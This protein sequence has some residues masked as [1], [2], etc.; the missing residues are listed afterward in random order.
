MSENKGKEGSDGAVKVRFIP[1]HISDFV[2]KLN[3]NS[4]YPPFARNYFVMFDK[5]I[6]ESITANGK[7]IIDEI[8]D[9]LPDEHKNKL[10]NYDVEYTSLRPFGLDLVIESKKKS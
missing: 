5:D 6:A 1:K 10:E 7:C 3:L 8:K 2:D 4:Y 9:K